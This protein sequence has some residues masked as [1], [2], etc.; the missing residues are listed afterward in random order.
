MSSDANKG[1]ILSLHNHPLKAY[2]W[3]EKLNSAYSGGFYCNVCSTS[4]P[5]TV[6]NFHCTD[7][8]YDLCD[9][10]LYNAVDSEIKKQEKKK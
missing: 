3:D 2:K 9:K 8:E 1:Y 7:C 4:Y 10:C 5:K 6:I